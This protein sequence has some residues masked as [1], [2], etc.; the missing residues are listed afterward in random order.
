MRALAHDTARGGVTANSVQPGWIATASST[1]RE[2][3]AGQLD[4]GRA[5]GQR[6]RGGGRGRVPR[7]RGGRVHHRPDARRRRRQHHPGSPRGRRLLAEA[8]LLPAQPRAACTSATRSTS[9]GVVEVMADAGQLVDRPRRRDGRA[10][11]ARSWACTSSSPPN[12]SSTGRS[13]ARLAQRAHER[14]RSATARG[15]RVAAGRASRAGSTR[16]VRGAPARGRATARAGRRP[17]PPGRRSA[18]PAA[19]SR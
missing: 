4:A 14:A 18:R 12:R 13:P 16:R 5:G 1:E 9:S 15:R 8:E 3:E 11:S 6:T 2:L 10:G 19:H 17:P 7:V